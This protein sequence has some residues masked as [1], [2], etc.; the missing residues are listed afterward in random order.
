MPMQNI[1]ISLKSAQDRRRHIKS[2]F[3]KHNVAFSFFDA[4]TPDLAKARALD[5]KINNNEQVLSGGEFAC[6]MS[7]VSI[8]QKMI[9]E[10]IPYLTIFEDDIYL[11]E[12]AEY[13]LNTFDWIEP[14]WN[15][16]KIEAFSKK[17]FLSADTHEI[18]AN[19]RYISE[20]KRKNLGA[21]GYILSLH[22][23]KVYLDYI[24]N[25][26][27][28]PVDELMFNTFISEK[29][30]PVYQM[31]PALCIQEMVLNKTK[32]G[33]LLP[34]SLEVNRRNRMKLEKK[35]GLMKVRKEAIRL[36][37]QAKDA[38]FAKETPFK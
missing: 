24:L 10:N 22:G 38:L 23:A 9:D 12:D 30:E 11:G 8:W 1:V 37:S 18:I 31:T 16:I 14:E 35:G 27:L 3:Q 6:M 4:L 33:L 17:A 29:T 5:I 32:S 34:S 26:N 19:K 15:I 25:S 28:L 36:V 13:L 7:H 2:E 20:L 21:A